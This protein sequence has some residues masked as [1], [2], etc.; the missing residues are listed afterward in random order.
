MSRPLADKWFR[1][2][3]LASA[4]LSGAVVVLVVLF[5]LVASWPALADLGP[6]RYLT[7][8]RWYP[9]GGLWGMSAMIVGTL[10][11]TLGA[12]LLAAPLGILSAVFCHYYAPARMATLYRRLVELLAG[13]PS[14]VYG[15]WGLVVLVPIIARWHPPGTS[16]LAAILVLTLMILPTVALVADSALGQLPGSQV[17]GAYALGLSRA[18]VIWRIAV[19]A[20][21]RALATGTLLATARA[22]GETMAVLMVCGGVVNLPTSLFEPIRTLTA[23]IALEMSYA[24]GLHRS[25]L[26]VT[27]LVLVL[28][29]VTLVTVADRLGEEPT[30]G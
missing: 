3:L 12:V 29:V 13:I 25:S 8:T 2:G 10:L 7:D 15:L 18:G 6:G 23:N 19:P 14:V 21:R 24:E 9:S 1:W 20:A 26:F 4:A 27:G 11:S 17:A 5:L 22:I 28:A 30:G 16:L